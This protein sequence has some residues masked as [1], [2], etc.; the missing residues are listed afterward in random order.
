MSSYGAFILTAYL[1]VFVI[2]GGLVIVSLGARSRVRRELAARGLDRPRQ[3][4]PRA[5]RAG[6]AAR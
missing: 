4:R 6:G 3:G 1:C 2:L 5:E